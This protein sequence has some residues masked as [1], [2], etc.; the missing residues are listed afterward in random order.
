MH[1]TTSNDEVFANAFRDPEDDIRDLVRSAKIASYLAHEPIADED[2]DN[3]A[4]HALDR[5]VEQI[6]GLKRKYYE[7]Y[8]EGA[9]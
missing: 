7:I 1:V 2:H 3:L 6:T 5:V 9:P 4:L 8:G